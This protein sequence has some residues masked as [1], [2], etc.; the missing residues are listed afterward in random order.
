MF[1]KQLTALPA[2][3]LVAVAL[4]CAAPALSQG[5]VH[6]RFN[7]EQNVVI[8]Q[9]TPD[10]PDLFQAIWTMNS[11]DFGRTGPDG[12]MN[13]QMA[14]GPCTIVYLAY[15]GPGPDDY[16]P[17]AEGVGTFQWSGTVRF[18]DPSD[19]SKGVEA[20][21]DLT[22]SLHADFSPGGAYSSLDLHAVVRDYQVIYWRAILQ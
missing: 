11:G 2:M 13:I 16:L 1:R 10:G 12:T 4:Y 6:V 8:G 5:S 14:S 21:S 19:P 22:E 15:I 7:G 3:L 18:V 17:V 20:D 9:V